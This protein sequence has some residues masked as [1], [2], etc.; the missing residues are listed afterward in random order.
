MKFLV[1]AL[2]AMVATAS[3]DDCSIT[4]LTSLVTNSNEPK[5]SSD[6]GYDFSSGTKPTPDEAKKMCASTACQ[7]FQAFALS[8]NP[9]ECTIPLGNHIKLRA[10]LLDYV[11]NI[12]AS[13]TATPTVTTATPSA[14]TAT[15]SS[16][17]ATPSTTTAIPTVTSSA[18]AC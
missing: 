17:T 15:P 1:L 9:A 11:A 7:A 14:T 16:T 8:T 3:A 5:C 18:P 4:Y 6:S 13:K 2:A 10:D 12:C